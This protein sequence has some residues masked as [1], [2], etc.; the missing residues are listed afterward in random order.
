MTPFDALELDQAATPAEVEA[1]WR[2]LRSTHHPDHGGDA[3]RFIMLRRAYLEARSLA[4]ERAVRAARCPAC[5][6]SGHH[7]VTRGNTSITM[8]CAECGGSGLS[9][10]AMGGDDGP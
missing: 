8:L 1:R 7:T 10:S 3:G 5:E 4:A 6:G 2:A 9:S